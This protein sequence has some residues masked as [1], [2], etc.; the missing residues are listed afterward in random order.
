VLFG[1]VTLGNGYNISVPN[2]ST[3]YIYSGA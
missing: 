1:P 2:A 3:L